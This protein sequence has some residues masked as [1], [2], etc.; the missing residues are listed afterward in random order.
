MNDGD[1]LSIGTISGLTPKRTP[2]I[3]SSW[4]PRFYQQTRANGN[5]EG[6]LNSWIV[7]RHRERLFG[8]CSQHLL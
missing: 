5:Q 7:I 6:K 1:L 8:P 3:D 2:V 4:R